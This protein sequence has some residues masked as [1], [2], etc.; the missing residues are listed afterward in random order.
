MAGISQACRRSHSTFNVVGMEDSRIRFF[1]EI[2]EME[3]LRSKQFL[4]ELCRVMWRRGQLP[5]FALRNSSRDSSPS[6]WDGRSSSSAISISSSDVGNFSSPSQATSAQCIHISRKAVGGYR[7][8]EGARR[9]CLWCE[10][11]RSRR[12]QYTF[13]IRRGKHDL[14]EMPERDS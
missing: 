10:E 3:K 8:V 1:A 2:R 13:I 6:E 9:V 11:R 14:K 5:S 7:R 12:G 4:P